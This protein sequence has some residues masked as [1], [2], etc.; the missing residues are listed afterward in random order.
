MISGVAG[1]LAEYFNV[2]PTAVRLIYAIVTVLTGVVPGIA[3]YLGLALIVPTGPVAGGA[4]TV[5]TQDRAAVA[6]AILVA[7]GVLIL[8]GNFGLFHFWSW[9]RLWPVILI[10]IGAAL[11]LRRRA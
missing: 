7:V 1:G 6:G 11:L 4:G 2:D 10:A 9:G 3:L 8:L 5:E